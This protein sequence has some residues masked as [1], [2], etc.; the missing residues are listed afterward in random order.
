[1]IVAVVMCRRRPNV[2]MN[3]VQTRRYQQLPALAN[4]VPELMSPI[5]ERSPSFP[6]LSEE[7][8]CSS[9]DKLPETTRSSDS[10][11]CEVERSETKPCATQRDLQNETENLQGEEEEQIIEMFV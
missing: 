3:K 6:Q 11:P 8:V 5:C 7:I 9:E 1:M 10:P 2:Q 4:I